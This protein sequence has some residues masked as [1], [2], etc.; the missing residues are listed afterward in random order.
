M[1][2][3]L[4]IALFASN[5]M[6][7]KPKAKSHHSSSRAATNFEKKKQLSTKKDAVGQRQARKY[8]SLVPP[9]FVNDEESKIFEMAKRKK[10]LA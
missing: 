7:P 1:Q 9:R 4:D 2:L 3:I 6:V 8:K 5:T 10:Y